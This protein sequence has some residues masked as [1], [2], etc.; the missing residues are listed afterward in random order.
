MTH[1][2]G[3]NR[4]YSYATQIEPKFVVPSFLGSQHVVE[5]RD[6]IK[7]KMYTQLHI[8]QIHLAS[9]HL[10]PFI[11]KYTTH[12]RARAHTHTDICLHTYIRRFAEYSE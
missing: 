2:T 11:T 3:L 12:T 9:C 7:L 1:L 4:N 5:F 8:M 10:F 6:A